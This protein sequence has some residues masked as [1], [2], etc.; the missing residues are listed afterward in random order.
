MSRTSLAA[1][2]IL[3]WAASPAQAQ[4]AFVGPGSTV[5]GDYLRGVGVAAFGMGIYNHETAIASRSTP[6]P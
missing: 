4:F 3:I 1:F 5:Q 2:L 6:T